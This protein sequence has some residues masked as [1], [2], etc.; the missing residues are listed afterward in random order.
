MSATGFWSPLSMSLT[1]IA[2]P[3]MTTCVAPTRSAC[4]NW[5]F[6]ERPACS[7]WAC[8]P[9]PRSASA[10]LNAVRRCSGSVTA[11]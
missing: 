5:P 6:I 1:S 8:T 10:I 3:T 7:I 4:L 11:T 9:R 2:S